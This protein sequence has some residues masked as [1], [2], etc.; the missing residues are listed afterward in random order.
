MLIEGKGE[1]GAMGKITCVEESQSDIVKRKNSERLELRR[2][3]PERGGNGMVE[4]LEAEKGWTVAERGWKGK[5]CEWRLRGR[6]RG[7]ESEGFLTRSV[8]G[9]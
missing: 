1:S 6:R 4:C 3:E 8:V 7:E 5:G 2:V 9:L